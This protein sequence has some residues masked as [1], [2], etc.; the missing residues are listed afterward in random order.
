MDTIWAN[1]KNSPQMTEDCFCT[2][3]LMVKCGVGSALVFGSIK[4]RKPTAVQNAES[5]AGNQCSAAFRATLK[6]FKRRFSF[7]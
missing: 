1:C 5:T 2:K 7:F 6:S 4:F 3:A